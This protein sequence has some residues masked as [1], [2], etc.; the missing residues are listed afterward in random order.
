MTK[1]VLKREICFIKAMISLCKHGQF[2][3]TIKVVP[4]RI[5]YGYKV[6]EI[7]KNAVKS[8]V[9]IMVICISNV[10]GFSR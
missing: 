10:F 4:G 3:N 8:G 6:A 7:K 1:V 9:M 2:H 5:N